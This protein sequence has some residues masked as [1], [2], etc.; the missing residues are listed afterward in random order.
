MRQRARELNSHKID[1]RKNNMCIETCDDTLN[2]TMNYSGPLTAE[3]YLQCA[4]SRLWGSVLARNS[5]I[6]FHKFTSTAAH[7]HGSRSTAYMPKA[8]QQRHTQY[9][10]H[11][12]TRIFQSACLSYAIRNYHVLLC[13]VNEKKKH[14]EER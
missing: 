10:L 9:T 6:T 7:M 13:L 1:E 8:A 2:G 12:Q 11:T 4:P 14:E 5:Q 3:N